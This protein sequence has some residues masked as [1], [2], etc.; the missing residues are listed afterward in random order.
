MKPTAWSRAAG[1]DAT[2]GAASS[3]DCH[4]EAAQQANA[5]LSHAASASQ[6]HQPPKA[7]SG[8][9]SIAPVNS[10]LTSKRADGNGA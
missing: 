1:C 5:A 6:R 10:H 4:R 9:H 7:P 3:R 8:Q 2:R